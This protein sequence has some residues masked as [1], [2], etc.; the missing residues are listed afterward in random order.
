MAQSLIGRNDNLKPIKAYRWFL[1]KRPNFQQWILAEALPPKFCYLVSPWE[2][3]DRSIGVPKT[4]GS[5]WLNVFERAEKPP[6]A[7]AV[8]A[9]D[10]QNV[11]CDDIHVDRNL[12]RQGLASFLYKV[13]ADFFEAIIIPSNTQLPG[14]QSFWKNQREVRPVGILDRLPIICDTDL[15]RVPTQG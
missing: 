7:Y 8:F 4:S 11:R 1:M 5:L 13:A 14:G 15:G 12:R 2:T 3:D 9:G 6:V 10:S